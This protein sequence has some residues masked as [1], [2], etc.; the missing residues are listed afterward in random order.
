M[1]WF[2]TTGCT[3]NFI[4][5]KSVTSTNW[6]ISSVYFDGSNVDTGNEMAVMNARDI[7]DRDLISE[8]TS[9]YLGSGDL[10]S[11]SIMTTGGEALKRKWGLVT[12]HS[13]TVMAFEELAFA[14]SNPLVLVRLRNPWG[15]GVIN[16]TTLEKHEWNGD[17]SDASRKWKK[18]PEI[19]PLQVWR[20]VHIRERWDVL[21]ELEGF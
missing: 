8:L 19:A 6:R 13:Y 14:D 5:K 2:W 4:T 15:S 17:W 3:P 21:D 10:L 9:K 20:L 16:K 7:S 12:T 11:A 18:H 1:G